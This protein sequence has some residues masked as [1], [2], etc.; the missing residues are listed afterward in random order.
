MGDDAQT[1]ST[2]SA[3]LEA[4]AKIEAASS[5]FSKI[6]SK[7]S[8]PLLTNDL[9]EIRKA[10]VKAGRRTPLGKILNIVPVVG[11]VAAV[12]DLIYGIVSANGKAKKDNDDNLQAQ[13][14]GIKTTARTFGISTDQFHEFEAI[15]TAQSSLANLPDFFKSLKVLQAKL[16]SGVLSDDMTSAFKA[17]ELNPEKLAKLD[18]ATLFRIV[19]KAF[20]N[21]DKTLGDG[22][23]RTQEE[24][25]SAKEGFAKTLAGTLDPHQLRLWTAKSS[26]IE[27]TVAQSYSLPSYVDP[28]TH[29]SREL[30]H[31]RDVQLKQLPNRQSDSESGDTRLRDWDQMKV[32]FD[33]LMKEHFS[34]IFGLGEFGDNPR[35]IAN[36]KDYEERLSK[37]TSKYKNIANSDR[38]AKETALVSSAV[39]EIATAIAKKIEPFVKTKAESSQN[40]TPNQSLAATNFNAAVRP[41]MP[42]S[43]VQQISNHISVHPPSVSEFMT[44]W[45]GQVT[46]IVKTE[47]A[48]HS[49]QAIDAYYTSS[50]AG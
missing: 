1:N 13:S 8:L 15:R 9:K 33:E 40:L 43:V 47:I 41:D 7:A 4:T 28:E 39:N 18:P 37:E 21:S 26:K 20:E 36:K 14:H 49:K 45:H 44:A 10:R 6:L 23:Y 30:A 16:E 32:S 38:D 27:D 22:H 34:R 17:L 46:N 12:V 50:A 42:K 29:E 3:L 35:R 25:S 19:N 24:Y 31:A 11:E 2:V 5:S 48:R